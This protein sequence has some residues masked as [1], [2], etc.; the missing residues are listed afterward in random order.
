MQVAE[1]KLLSRWEAF[2]APIVALALALYGIVQ[3]DADAIVV[4][5]ALTVIGTVIVALIN[6]TRRELDTGN[7]KAVGH[8][9]H[10]TAGTMEAVQGQLHDL[11]K[12]VDGHDRELREVNSTLVGMDDRLVTILEVLEDIKGEE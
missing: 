3:S 12:R 8:Q 10:E 7:G 9:V 2:T 6:R 5:A 4:G 11:S 1:T